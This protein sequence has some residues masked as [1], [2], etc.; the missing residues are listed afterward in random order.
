MQVYLAPD[1]RDLLDRLATEQG[2]SRAEILRRGIRSYAAEQPAQSPM[3]R[4]LDGAASGKWAAEPGTARRHDEIL[5]KGY[6][7]KRKRR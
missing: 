2:L 3:L 7:G 1:E 4:F 5:A 6:R